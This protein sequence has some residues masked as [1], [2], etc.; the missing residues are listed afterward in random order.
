MFSSSGS[1]MALGYALR[2]VLDALKQPYQS[3][4]YN[5]GITALDRFKVRLKEYHKYCEYI[6][7]LPHFKN[8]PPSLI[9][10]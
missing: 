3:K 2:F 5:F 8:F 4:M 10:V 9:E 7:Q 1:Y 6:S